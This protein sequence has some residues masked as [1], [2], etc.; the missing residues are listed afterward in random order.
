MSDS[1]GND[2]SL[3]DV[4]NQMKAAQVDKGDDS[5]RERVRN[6]NWAPPEQFN[7]ESYN[8]GQGEKGDNVKPAPDGL[9]WAANA[10]KYEWLD[11]FG[12]V[13]PEFKELELELFGDETKTKKGGEYAK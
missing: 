9:P 4:T 7:Y 3:A 13:G 6:A 8:S 12:D 5:A 10:A 1:G 2:T 11:D